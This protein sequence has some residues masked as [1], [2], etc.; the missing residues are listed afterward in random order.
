MLGSMKFTTLPRAEV[1][2]ALESESQPAGG[3]AAKYH[4]TLTEEER[5]Q[6]ET[7]TQRQEY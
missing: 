5:T 4:V 2:A 3:L 7:L 1:A 6:L